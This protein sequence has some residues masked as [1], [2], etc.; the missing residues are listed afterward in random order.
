ML[1]SS[2]ATRAAD[3]H[4]NRRQLRGMWGALTA[5]PVSG[6]ATVFTYT[7][8][9]QPFHPDVA[10]PNVIAIVVLAEQDDLRMATNIVGAEHD[11]LRIRP[12]GARALRAARRRVLPR[13]RTG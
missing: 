9:M 2:A 11:A 10:P 8:N 12:T 3:G 13:V 5:S 7:V 1:L 6:D 4:C